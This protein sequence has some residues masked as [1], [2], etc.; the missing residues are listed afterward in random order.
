MF[1]KR[2]QFLVFIVCMLTAVYAR[3]SHIVLLDSGALAWRGVERALLF[4]YKM[5]KDYGYQVTFLADEQGLMHKACTAI[6][7][8]SE[9][10]QKRG[11]TPADELRARMTDVC[12]A[13]PVDIVI[14]ARRDQLPVLKKLREIFKFK[15]VFIQNVPLSLSSHYTDSFAQRQVKGIDGVLAVSPSIKDEFLALNREYALGIKYID[16][17]PA[18]TDDQRFTA[19]VPHESRYA[20]FKKN[21]NVDVGHVPVLCMIANFYTS[22]FKRHDVLLHALSHLKNKGLRFHAFLAG[23]GATRQEMH[24][25]TALLGLNDCVHFTGFVDSALLLA[26]SDMHVLSS[27]TREAEGSVSIEAGYLKKPVIA[28]RGSGADQIITDGLNGYLFQPNDV[29]DLAKAIEALLLSPALCKQ[30]GA[31]HYQHVME[32][33]SMS[34]IFKQFDAYCHKLLE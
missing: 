11:A 23:E 33:F 6:G 19:C 22:G 2:C 3:S 5:L 17:M 15:I 10:V 31:A 32:K 14:A 26:H 12:S 9:L 1:L 18:P 28:A 29:A 34:A 25:L 7:L 21:F 30:Q 8:P 13:K 24:K 4:R 16:S 20:Y 27:D